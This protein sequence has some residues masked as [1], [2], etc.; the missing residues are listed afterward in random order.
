MSC[1]ECVLSPH[2]STAVPEKQKGP[3]GVMQGD[4]LASDLVA[5]AHCCHNANIIFRS[6]NKITSSE[7]SLG[8]LDGSWVSVRGTELAII[9]CCEEAWLIT[10]LY[11]MV[12]FCESF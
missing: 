8:R 12:N 3:N 9:K 11:S 5:K 4:G 7:D 1:I 10:A 2:G 6:Y